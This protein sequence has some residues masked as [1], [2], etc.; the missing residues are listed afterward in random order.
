[1]KTEFDRHQTDFAWSHHIYAFIDKTDVIS[2]DK[3]FVRQIQIWA[4]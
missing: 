1:M 3:L 2:Q 4:Y